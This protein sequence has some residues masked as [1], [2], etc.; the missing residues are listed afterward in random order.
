MSRPCPGSVPVQPRRG[1]RARAPPSRT[2]LTHRRPPGGARARRRSAPR[3]RKARAGP[4]HDVHCGA[5]AR[6]WRAT[7][8]CATTWGTRGSSDTSSSSSNSGRTVRAGRGPGGGGRAAGGGAGGPRVPPAWFNARPL[9]TGKLRYANN[10]N[11]KNDVMIRKEVRA[12]RL[13]A[14]GQQE[15]LWAGFGVGLPR[16]QAC[17]YFSAA[18]LCPGLRAQECDG[19]AEEN[20][21]RQ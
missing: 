18:M 9:P 15:G 11:Y 6:P 10:S 20:N 5:A 4:I 7:F 12:A 19:G 17:I 14:R 8:T 21:R 2:T 1:G 3:A 13:R 16:G